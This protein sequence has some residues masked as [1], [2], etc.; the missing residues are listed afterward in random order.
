VSLHSDWVTRILDLEQEIDNANAR[1]LELAQQKERLIYWLLRFITKSA[2]P[3]DRHL[4]AYLTKLEYAPTSKNAA[5][6]LELGEP[7]GKRGTR[8]I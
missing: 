5:I 8:S 4:A 1:A 6:L 7:G 3:N 2:E